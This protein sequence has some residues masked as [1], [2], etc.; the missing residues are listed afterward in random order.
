MKEY[1]TPKLSVLYDEAMC[2]HS[3]IC[4]KSLPTVFNLGKQPWIDLGGADVEAIIET[5]SRCP[6]KALRFEIKT[7]P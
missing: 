2:T 7:E 4:V 1:Y 3:G 6:S 5:I